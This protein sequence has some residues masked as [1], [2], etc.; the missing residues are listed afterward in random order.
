MIPASVAADGS[1]RA[2]KKPNFGAIAEFH[3][4]GAPNIPTNYIEYYLF[5]NFP[6]LDSGYS[7]FLSNFA[8]TT[9]RSGFCSQVTGTSSFASFRPPCETR[10]T[11]GNGPAGGRIM[12]YLFKGTPEI[13]TSYFP[14]NVM[15]DMTDSDGNILMHFW[16][17][18][19]HW[20]VAGGP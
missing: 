2:V 5:G 3:C 18:S 16:D 7:F 9:R 14:R 17:H 10:Y 8:H 1:C 19:P 20:L 11:V 4:V 12:E 6:T 13:T 15:V